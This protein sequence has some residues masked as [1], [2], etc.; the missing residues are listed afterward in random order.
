MKLQ[1]RDECLN[2]DDLN[3]IKMMIQLEKA[4]DCLIWNKELGEKSK[5][6]IKFVKIVRLVIAYATI[7]G[8]GITAIAVLFFGNSAMWPLRGFCAVFGILIILWAV[9][10]GLYS[11]YQVEYTGHGRYQLVIR[12]VQLILTEFQI[13]LNRDEF[14]VFETKLVFVALAGY[15]D[16]AERIYYNND[17]LMRW[18]RYYNQKRKNNE[19]IEQDIQNN[20]ELVEQLSLADGELDKI[21]NKVLNNEKALINQKNI[22]VMQ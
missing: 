15:L 20:H 21:V 8:M 19:S 1:E 16:A 17:K 6:W 22:E 12:Q 7:L 10:A 9:L 3:L 2:N 4:D 11:K 5:T 18:V 13:L 14:D